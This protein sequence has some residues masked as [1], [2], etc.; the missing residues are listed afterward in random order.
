MRPAAFG[1]YP[2]FCRDL[3]QFPG[4]QRRVGRGFTPP[5]SRGLAAGQIRT[6]LA[7]TGT[8][9]SNWCGERPESLTGQIHNAD[10]RLLGRRV[11]CRD[12]F[13]MIVRSRCLETLLVCALVGL[14]A[15]TAHADPSSV[16]ISSARH[17]FE[18][19]VALEND[20][21]W[22]EASLKLREALAV[23]DTPGLRFHLAHCETELGQLVEAALDYD[24]ASDLIQQGAKA[25]DVQKLLV[26]T[27]AALRQR[28]PRVSVDVPSDLLAPVATLDGK[29]YPPSEISLG[30][31]LNPGQHQ[32]S[33]SASGRRS[34]ERSFSLKEGQVLQL[35]AELPPA[36]APAAPAGVLAPPVTAAS[37]PDALQNAH[38]AHGSSTR[39]YLLIG[40]TVVTLA[41]LAV[42]IGGVAATSSAND[43]VSTAQ[44]RI[45]QASQGDV[46]AC[47]SPNGP[48]A[49]ACSD[50]RT[51]IDDHDRAVLLSEIGFVTAGVG[52]AAL[53]TTWLAYPSARGE[54]SG[55]TVR[56]VAGLGHVG[57]IGRF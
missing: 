50:L 24:R 21:H 38:G 18:T 16:E 45:D 10:Y 30:V 33:V 52:A 20:Q 39:T 12:G 7:R 19:A 37:G 11:G 43:R 5:V 22:S 17:A 55:I 54:A 2:V 28:I 8:F 15:R 42:G 6:R 49:G 41:G 46:A 51:A 40:E 31:G 4:S 57:L 56:P 36:A 47:A 44:G 9:P 3:Q 27:S 35:R 25:P 26:P 13:F 29:V 1:L 48:V 32:L 23:K 53:L 34:F 14:A